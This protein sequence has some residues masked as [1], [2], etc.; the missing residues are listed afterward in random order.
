M[1]TIPSASQTEYINSVVLGNQRGKAFAT[2]KRK[3]T[4][5]YILPGLHSLDPQV[6]LFKYNLTKAANKIAPLQILPGH[7]AGPNAVP[8]DFSKLITAMP[9]YGM[10]PLTIPLVDNFLARKEVGLERRDLTKREL[11]IHK[12]VFKAMHST[13]DYTRDLMLRKE[14]SMMMPTF[15]TDPLTKRKI[16]EGTIKIVDQLLDLFIKGRLDE[17]AKQFGFVVCLATLTRSQPDKVEL[18]DL[19]I[20]KMKERSVADKEYALSGGE[21]GERSPASKDVLINGVKSRYS[22]A[23]RERT[24]Y[25]AAGIVNMLIAALY[26]P[27]RVYQDLYAFTLKH[28]T[29]AEKKAKVQRYNFS[30]GVDVHQHDQMIA[31]EI[32]DLY[33]ELLYTAF[34]PRVAVL[35]ESLMR[36]PVYVPQPDANSDDPGFWLGNPLDPSSFVMKAG[37]YSGIANNPDFGKWNMISTYL[38]E[39]DL[40]TKD[41]IEVGVEKILRGEHEGYGLLDMTDDALYLFQKQS[42]AAAMNARLESMSTPE[43]TRASGAFMHRIEVETPKV[44][45]GDVFYIRDNQ[46]EVAPSPVSYLVNFWCPEYPCDVRPYWPIGWEARQ[47]HYSTTPLY[48]DLYNLQEKMFYDHFNVHLPSVINRGKEQM[49][50]RVLELERVRSQREPDLL[51]HISQLSAEDRLYLMNP[52]VI[53]YKVNPSDL[54]DIIKESMVKISGQFIGEH[55]SHLILH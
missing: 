39:I 26:T 16:V 41:V 12:L 8:S 10:N 33:C 38:C 31:E 13:S 14:A 47:L 45:L 19:G 1:I 25:G 6:I 20:V 40:I 2:R 18:D 3:R 42:H 44:F 52:D 17:L 4:G 9:N 50:K 46:I 29:P 24:A 43:G 23:S 54:S 51:G 5:G 49:Q 15:E 34:D 53:H 55:L 27:Y 37:L 32:V 35:I 22:Q 7:F 36:A 48:G 21:K 11:L 30:V 28:R